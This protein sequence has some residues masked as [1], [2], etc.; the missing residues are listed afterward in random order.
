MIRLF[1]P[2]LGIFKNVL[3][4]EEKMYMPTLT[5]AEIK[6]ETAIPIEGL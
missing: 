5:S 6:I 2:K 4:R 1:K 3:R